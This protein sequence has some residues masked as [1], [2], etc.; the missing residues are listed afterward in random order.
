MTKFPPYGSLRSLPGVGPKIADDYRRL[1]IDDAAAVAGADP[2][3]LYE[4][5]ELLDGPTDRCMLYVLRCAH[6]AATTANPDAELLDWWKWK[7][8][9]A[10]RP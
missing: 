7:D 3:E 4:R 2:E 8:D 5:I 10:A 1:G 6:Y 9:H